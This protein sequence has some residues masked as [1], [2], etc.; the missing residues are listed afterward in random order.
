MKV[1]TKNVYYHYAPN[2]LK[3]LWHDCDKYKGDQNR[4]IELEAAEQDQDTT[5]F[6]CPHCEF[7]YA[8]DNHL[9]L[10]RSKH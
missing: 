9:E 3:R 2:R 10:I 5:R 8:L 7:E 1:L 6:C 4:R